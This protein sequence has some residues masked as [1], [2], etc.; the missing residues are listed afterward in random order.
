M[1]AYMRMETIIQKAI[2]ARVFPG[3]VCGVASPKS[4][5]E[6]R[7]FGTTQYEDAGSHAVEAE[8]IYDIASLTKLFTYTATLQLVTENKLDLLEPLF[9]HFPQC[10]QGKKSGLN[11]WH[12][13]THSAGWTIRT[14]SLSH[15]RDRAKLLDAI[16]SSDLT[17]QPGKKIWYTNNYPFILGELIT[18]VT[19]VPLD[20]YFQKRIFVP[21][22]MTSTRFCP[23][24]S[25]KARI[26]P[27]ERDSV[28][29]LIH[30]EAHDPSA[31]SIGGVSG[32]AGLF[33]CAADLLKF[34]QAWLRMEVPGVDSALAKAAVTV[35]LSDAQKCEIGLGWKLNQLWMGLRAPSGTFGYTGFTGT[36]IAVSPRQ[37]RAVVLLSNRV[38]PSAHGPDRLAVQARMLN[39]LWR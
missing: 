37:D 26:A 16:L 39:T 21:L 36:M 31:W 10:R 29:G 11:L 32:Q 14:S 18:R 35:Q 9:L 1:I 7:A 3:V 25:W 8:T 5:K 4:V 20:Q 22:R 19:G 2:T 30:G 28:R 23:P 13:L 34:G 24:E 15:L 27:T 17:H 6:I 12:L 38:Y 33:S